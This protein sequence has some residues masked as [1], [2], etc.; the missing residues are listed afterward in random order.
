MPKLT[1]PSVTAAGAAARRALIGVPRS[2]ADRAGP[3]FGRVAGSPDRRLAL[4]RYRTLADT[5]ELRT[6]AGDPLRRLI[7]DRLAPEPGEIVL[8]VG[9][10]TGL[11]FAPMEDA[12]G[13][14]GR[15]IGIDPSPEML[16]LA[17]ART[18]RA[19]WRNVLLVQAG[20]EEADVQMTADAALLC[21]VHDV[22]RSPA[23]LGNVL[24][25]LRDGGRIVAGGAKWAPWWRPGSVALNLS[26]WSINRDY[27][28]SFEGFDRPWSHLARLVPD[29]SVEELYL[30]A[31][32]IASGTRPC[33]G[34]R[35]HT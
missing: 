3:L 9:C 11:N 30:G 35:R 10:G 23:A 32:Y 26:T 12:I 5:Y 19:G 14:R 1:L 17:R 22:M 6:I 27:V 24:R 33:T 13:P 16:A 18:D 34:G 28:T 25:Q 4:E 31:G 15:L 7:V 29:L 2:V 21:A 20:A 8:D